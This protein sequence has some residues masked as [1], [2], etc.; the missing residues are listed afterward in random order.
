MRSKDRA[1]S[2]GSTRSSTRRQAVSLNRVGDDRGDQTKSRQPAQGSN[3]QV[4]L[5]ASSIINS[6]GWGTRY[7][8][9]TTGSVNPRVGGEPK[10]LQLLFG[11]AAPRICVRRPRC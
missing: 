2:A 7:L 6:S 5:V 11:F 3:Q 4:G 10:L 9:E 1:T 8:R